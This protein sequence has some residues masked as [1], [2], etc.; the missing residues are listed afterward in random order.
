MIGNWF[1]R[2][3][4]YF[5]IYFFLK[6]KCIPIMFYKDVFNV[7]EFFILFSLES[8]VPKITIS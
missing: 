7:I 4:K 3:V 1:K 6:H 2:D 8:K 5:Q